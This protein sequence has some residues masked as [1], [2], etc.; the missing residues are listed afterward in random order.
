MWVLI[1]RDPSHMVYM[2]QKPCHEWCEWVLIQ[3]DPSHMVI[4]HRSLA[5][6]DVSIDTKGSQPHGLYV[7][8]ALPWVMWVSID[9]KGSQPHGYMSQKPC[10]EWCEWV[11]ILRD[12]SHTVIFHTQTDERAVALFCRAGSRWMF[13]GFSDCLFSVTWLYFSTSI[14]SQ[15][16]HSF[17]LLT[18][19]WE[20]FLEI[21]NKNLLNKFHQKLPP[22][23]QSSISWS[24]L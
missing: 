1:L 10:C 3:R 23:A 4:C 6:S 22:V 18:N 12:P 24:S 17:L 20:L 15:V 9:T 19:L 7:T 21:E 16:R 5:V 13:W 11:L 14:S 8:E 2:S